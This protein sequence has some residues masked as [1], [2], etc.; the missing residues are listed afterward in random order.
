MNRPLIRLTCCL[1]ALAG[2]LSSTPASALS[3]AQPL[4]PGI[5]GLGWLADLA[6]SSWVGRV[7]GGNEAPT[8]VCWWFDG[9]SPTLLM[10]MQGPVQDK[11][12]A[13]FQAME[14]ILDISVVEA[15]GQLQQQWKLALPTAQDRAIVLTL[16]DGN[17]A[18]QSSWR[19]V[20]EPIDHDHYRMTATY[21]YGRQ[22]QAMPRVTRWV[23]RRSGPCSGATG[24]AQGAAQ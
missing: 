18:M 6:G 12:I 7:Q 17:S 24:I 3:R 5:A 20:L 13:R 1:L 10:Q 21:A 2:A 23:F 4:P 11:R 22:M 19:T 8:S 15:Q 9:R 14:Q 16:G